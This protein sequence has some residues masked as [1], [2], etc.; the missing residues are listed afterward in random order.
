MSM[1]TE[2]VPSEVYNTTHDAIV[3]ALKHP[4]KHEMTPTQRKIYER[5]D[6]LYGLTMKYMNPGTR[7]RF[8]M[9]KFGISRAQ[10]FR[11]VTLMQKIFPEIIEQNPKFK[12]I[13]LAERLE[14]NATHARQ[15]GDYKS[16]A[17]SLDKA[18]QIWLKLMDPTDTDAP[19]GNNVFVLQQVILK[20]D[21]SK[22]VKH[23]DLD[24]PV[25]VPY[26]EL[27]DLLERSAQEPTESDLMEMLR[28]S[29]GDEESTTEA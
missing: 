6:F 16:V 28:K 2:M 27:Q 21:K 25:D 17:M 11:D 23:I 14:E 4:D 8:M 12:L 24:K 13:L 20:G 18:A 26:E 7:E 10:Y 29:N 1:S 22:E 19:R 3:R 9:E 5:C 15:K